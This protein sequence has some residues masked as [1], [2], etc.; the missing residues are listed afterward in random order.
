MYLLY[1]DESGV[2]ELNAGTSHFVLFGLAIPVDKWAEYSGQVA[3]IKR[4]HDLLGK[5]IHTAWMARKYPMQEHTPNFA[6][7]S[8]NDRRSAVQKKRQ[9]NLA[10]HGGLKQPGKLRQIKQ[11]YK[12]TE[13]YIHLTYDE[14]MS[15]LC[16]LAILI[17]QWLDCRLF[18]EAIEKKSYRYGKPYQQAFTM[19]VHRFESFLVNRG[20]HVNSDLRGMII[21]DNNQTEAAKLT[22]LMRTLYAAGTS[23]RDVEKIVETPLFVDSEFTEMIQLADLCAYATRRFFENNEDSLFNQIYQRFDRIGNSVV[24]IRHFTE[25]NACTCRVCTDHETQPGLFENT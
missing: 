25:K 1:I 24:G 15:I 13:N 19:L 11:M 9:H 23:W 7:L 21:Q 18:A 14:R 5:E 22:K 6:N 2:P 17:R 16:D 3:Q 4:R 12:K 10:R 8:R 20:R